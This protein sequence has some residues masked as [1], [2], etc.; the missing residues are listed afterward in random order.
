MG[1]R[2]AIV[3]ILLVGV[4]GNAWSDE[5]LLVCDYPSLPPASPSS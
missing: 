1:D 5:L 4:W 2:T 3:L